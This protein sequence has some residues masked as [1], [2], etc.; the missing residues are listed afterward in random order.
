MLFL[1]FLLIWKVTL[2]DFFNATLDYLPR[3]PELGCDALSFHYTVALNLLTVRW[4]LSILL[5]EVFILPPTLYGD[6]LFKAKLLWTKEMT[7]LLRLWTI[8]PDNGSSILGPTS[9]GS[10]NSSP[11][12]SD[13]PLWPHGQ[14]AHVHILTPRY[15]YIHAIEI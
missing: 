1:P 3:T 5:V 2:L 12:G 15:T 9:G 10:C 13:I 11:G 14:W 6:I 8:L 7:Q 4:G